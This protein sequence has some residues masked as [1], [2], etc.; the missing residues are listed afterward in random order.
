MQFMKNEF[1]LTKKQ[2]II[3]TA[4]PKFHMLAAGKNMNFAVRLK[5]K[6]NLMTVLMANW[7]FGAYGLGKRYLFDD[8]Q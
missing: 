5:L 8:L 1:R 4:Y 2:T 7:V 6:M 3:Q